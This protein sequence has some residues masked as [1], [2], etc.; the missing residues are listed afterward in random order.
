MNKTIKA[1]VA[2]GSAIISAAVMLGGCTP[3]SSNGS[4]HMEAIK[5]AEAG[6]QADDYDNWNKL[7][8]ENQI[9]EPFHEA[10]SQFAYQSASLVLSSEAD[11]INYSPLS[12]YYALALAG[13]GA[14]G[15]TAAQITN[16]L[17]IQDQNELA[18]QCRKLY[19]WIDY[20]EQRQSVLNEKYGEGTYDS[21]IQLGTSL[22][23]SD[24]MKLKGDYRKLAAS[25]FFAD[26]C[27]V[28]FTKQEAGE[29]I[30]RWIAEQTSGLLS[31]SVQLPEETMMVI[32]NTLYFYG[33]WSDTFAVA[34][35]ADDSFTKSDG[36]EVT[37]S[38]MN[39]VD[40]SGSFKRGDGYTVSALH[41][42]N[43][44]SMVFL[45]P[46]QGHDVEEYLNTPECL[47]AALSANYDEWMSGQVTWKVPKFSYG[48]SIKM[49][50]LLKTMGMGN[51]F[52]LEQA[53]FGKI[54]EL[55]L[56]VSDVIQET[57]IGIDEKGVEGAAYTMMM[58]VA[59]EAM[60]NKD[61]E[62][63]MIL[64]RPFIYGIQDNT[65]GTW[66]FLG[67]CRNP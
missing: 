32:L 41:T 34:Q 57:H 33:G 28:D 53:E 62:A 66:L 25:H 18:E 2:R 20:Y 1:K 35:T 5:V 8:D 6:Y 51:M 49:A 61:Q 38:F 9:S 13:C 30:G 11:N 55:P 21:T 12:L 4:K 54:S 43:D 59:G 48:S 36:S 40:S 29:Q 19:Q 16:A 47:E 23:I 31:P 7:L 42:N 46:D 22:W 15:E 17:G 50:E 52:M 39:R 58:L 44:C 60:P 45:L 27:Q 64:D 10:L 37:V 67:V 3:Y 14:D 24:R 63:D 26:S 56:F 65:T